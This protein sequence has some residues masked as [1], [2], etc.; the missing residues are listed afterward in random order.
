MRAI[1]ETSLG[2][3]ARLGLSNVAEGVETADNLELLRWLACQ[4]IQAYFTANPMPAEH[5]PAWAVQAQAGR[6]GA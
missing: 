2:L 6:D 4:E 5:V 1:L 3:G